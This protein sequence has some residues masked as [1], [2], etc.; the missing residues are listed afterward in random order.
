MSGI[1][2]ASLN[3]DKCNNKKVKSSQRRPNSG[4]PPNPRSYNIK[5]KSKAKH[6]GSLWGAVT[7]IV[8]FAFFLQREEWYA[9]VAPPLFLWIPWVER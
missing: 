9:L 6:Q 1:C 8:S 7:H 2:V 5:G 3:N 4:T